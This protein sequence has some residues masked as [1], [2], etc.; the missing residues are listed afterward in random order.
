MIET[1][2]IV[3]NTESSVLSM[4]LRCKLCMLVSLRIINGFCDPNHRAVLSS[5]IQLLLEVHS[6][7]ITPQHRECIF[8]F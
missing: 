2:S 6:E 7:L 4:V 8:H 5:L 1:N 3:M